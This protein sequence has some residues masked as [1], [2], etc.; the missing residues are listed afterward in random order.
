MGKQVEL[1]KEETNKSHKEIQ[2]N[3]TKQ[4][5]IIKQKKN[6]QALKVEIETIKSQAVVEHT[7]DCSTY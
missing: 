5:K 2:K 1:R 3:T 6:A 4:M 7:F